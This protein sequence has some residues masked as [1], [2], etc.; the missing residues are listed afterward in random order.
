MIVNQSIFVA[1]ANREQLQ[2][3]MTAVHI[4]HS[5]D[6]HPSQSLRNIFTPSASTS[7]QGS[8]KNR[9]ISSTPISGHKCL[10]CDDRFG[11]A[12]Y[13][14]QHKLEKH[15]KVRSGNVCRVCQAIMVT[16]NDFYGKLYVADEVYLCSS[17]HSVEHNSASD[18]S[19][20]VSCV[21]CGQ[22]LTTPVELEAHAVYHLQLQS[23]TTPT[24]DNNNTP[25][26]PNHNS[27][28]PVS[29]KFFG[30]TKI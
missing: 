8:A 15:C 29:F 6:I 19:G 5:K 21:V 27:P 12:H 28:K 18:P 10:I 13:L 4:N 14:T 26:T 30:F 3:H 17:G 23:A 1:F 20:N 9:S 22:T 11:S 24:T 25:S 7:H 2:L 16:V